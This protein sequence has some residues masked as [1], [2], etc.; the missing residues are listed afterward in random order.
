MLPVY[1]LTDGRSID[2]LGLTIFKGV[3][4]FKLAKVAKI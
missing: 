2:R 1:Q 3:Q 4:S